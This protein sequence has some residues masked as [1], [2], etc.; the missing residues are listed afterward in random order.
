VTAGRP[1]EQARTRRP[2]LL[3]LDVMMPLVD[4]HDVCRVLRAG[5]PTVADS[6]RGAVA[7]VNGE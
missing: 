6:R 4:G 3:A 7:D 2:D 1:F 5:G